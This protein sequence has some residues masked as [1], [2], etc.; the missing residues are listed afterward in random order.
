MNRRLRERLAHYRRLLAVSG[1]ALG[2]AILVLLVLAFRPAGD[3]DPVLLGTGRAGVMLPDTTAAPA[4]P[5]APA[6]PEPSS[7]TAGEGE[8]SYYSD[9]LAGNATASGEPYDPVQLTAAHRTLPLGSRVRVTNLRTD[10]SVVVRINDRGPF[11]K[12]R[13]I[14][15]SRAAAKRL[16]MLRAGTAP[17]RLE[18]LNT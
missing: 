14:D 1:G 2:V 8:A 4:A 9:Q 7:R 12:R 11:A 6:L 3:P 16:G 17:V 5:D 18:L 10:E 15:L 13:V